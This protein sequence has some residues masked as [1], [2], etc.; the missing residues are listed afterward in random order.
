MKEKTVFKVLVG[1]AGIATLLMW[2]TF[3]IGIVALAVIA[4]KL[5]GGS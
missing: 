2:G 4:G 1:V 3:A 5:V